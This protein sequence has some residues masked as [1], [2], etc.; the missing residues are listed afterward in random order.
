MIELVVLLDLPAKDQ[1][2]RIRL[3]VRGHDGLLR[4][5]GTTANRV[6]E[7]HEVD[8]LEAHGVLLRLSEPVVVPPRLTNPAGFWM[9]S[10]VAARNDQVASVRFP[11]PD[12]AI[13][14][15]QKPWE[16][17]VWLEE[18]DSIHERRDAWMTLLAWRGARVSLEEKRDLWWLMVATRPSHE[19]TRG[20][21]LLE[22]DEEAGLVWFDRQL[23][24][25]G[26]RLE[27]GEL[28]GAREK[29]LAEVRRIQ[30]LENVIAARNVVMGG[31]RKRASHMPVFDR[32]QPEAR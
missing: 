14:I 25:E 6:V 11:V 31:S 30:S 22:L 3:I 7:P 21:R 27:R 20:I 15:Q 8:E 9:G 24:T 5:S 18:P 19:L 4:T 2:T 28:L 16:G 26:K 17:V 13:R 32:Q 29:L 10:E 23:R 1:F 12:R